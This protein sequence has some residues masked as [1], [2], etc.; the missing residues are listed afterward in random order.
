MLGRRLLNLHAGVLLCTRTPDV[1]C[2]ALHCAEVSALAQA[3]SRFLR[4]TV[5]IANTLPRVTLLSAEAVC[6]A[7][8]CP[9]PSEHTLTCFAHSS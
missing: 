5:T 4:G 9:F 2:T 7:S 6:K 1:F 3:S 8:S